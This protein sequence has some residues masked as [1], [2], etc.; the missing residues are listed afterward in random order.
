MEEIYILE[1]DNNEKQTQ[2]DRVVREKRAAEEELELLHKEGLQSKPQNS[3]LFDDLTKRLATAEQSR[4][5]AQLK[6]QSLESK[7]K[8]MET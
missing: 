1:L 4:N 3:L 6:I 2:Y 8:K 5:Q 7:I